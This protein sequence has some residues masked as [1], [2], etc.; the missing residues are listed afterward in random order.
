M[1]QVKQSVVDC[2]SCRMERRAS[3]I[4]RFLFGQGLTSAKCGWLL[5][6]SGEHAKFVSSCLVK[7]QVQQRVVDCWLHSSHYCPSILVH[8][9]SSRT[10]LDRPTAPLERSIC[11]VLV[12]RWEN[13]GCF[14]LRQ[15]S[16][17]KTEWRARKIRRFL[18]GQGSSKRWAWAWAW[19]TSGWV[20]ITQITCHTRDGS[21]FTATQ[22]YF[23]RGLRAIHQQLLHL[24][25]FLLPVE[26]KDKKRK[27]NKWNE[28]RY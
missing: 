6:Q 15:R 8:L 7:V 24:L 20:S 18:L 13:R 12:K 26:T 10:G 19:A 23:V 27:E 9:T 1:V 28:V 14:L 25:L 16:S 17:K 22:A 11:R 3:K 2:R 5:M 21:A 4:R